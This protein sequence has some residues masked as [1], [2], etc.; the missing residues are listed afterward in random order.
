MPEKSKK[1]R[2]KSQPG[3]EKMALYRRYRPQKWSEI[4]GQDHVV[5]VLEGSIKTGKFSHAYL[6]AG[7]RGTGK[8]SIA[9]LFSRELGISE[10]DIM[11]I[12]AASNRGIDDIRELRDGVSSM[13]F[14][15][16]YKAYIIDEVHMLTKEAFNAFLKTLEEP[17]AHAIFILATTEPDALPETIISRCQVFHLKKPP[18]KVISQ[19]I[20]ATAKAEG[21]SLEKGVEDLIALFGDGSFR[22]ALGALQKI[23]SY[24]GD[25][26]ITLKEVQTVLGIP[27][28]KT[29]QNFIEALSKKDKELAVGILNELESSGF[30]PGFFTELVLEKMRMILIL[31]ISSNLKRM[32]EEKLSTE[33]LVFISDEASKKES[34][35]NS[36]LLAELLGT[37]SE[38][39][40]T[41]RKVLPLE[42]FVLKNL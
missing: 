37:L 30:D 14:G 20:A 12:D 17:P 15:S 22:D 26:E 3:S 27:D 21:Y 1:D 7:P 32:I 40:H 24:S 5:K 28:F 34:A 25:S 6:L 33:E 9:R 4:V 11:E 35:I 2:A 42:I 31:R 23:I 13:P 16:P 10:N 41:T 36:N 39:G 19:V 8:T 18:H 38:I 29:V